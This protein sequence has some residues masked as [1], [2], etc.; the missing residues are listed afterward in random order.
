MLGAE[1]GFRNCESAVDGRLLLGG[2]FSR[3]CNDL[4][5]PGTVL[6]SAGKTTSPIQGVGISNQASLA[7]ETAL[8][9]SIL[10]SR[11]TKSNQ[12][13]CGAQDGHLRLRP[14]PAFALM[15]PAPALLYATSRAV[16]AETDRAPGSSNLI[17]VY[18][19]SLSVLQY[20]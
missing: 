12:N 6:I 19:V 11:V 4:T 8:V 9:L 1:G 14:P 18:R 2:T 3:E 15:G 5:R 13:A 7:T 16:K 17:Y 10:T 20:Y